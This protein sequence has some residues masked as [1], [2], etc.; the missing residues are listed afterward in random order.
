M[1]RT[2]HGFYRSKAVILRLCKKRAI[3]PFSWAVCVSS[4]RDVA[5]SKRSRWILWGVQPH[6]IMTA[7]PRQ[8]K[9]CA[10]SP[11][12]SLTLEAGGR[13]FP[14]PSKSVALRK[15]AAAPPSSSHRAI[16]AWWLDRLDDNVL[17]GSS[18]LYMGSMTAA[19]QQAHR[20]AR[21]EPECSRVSLH[22]S[23]LRNCSMKRRAIVS[24]WPG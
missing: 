16:A 18:F 4:G 13:S 15:V 10:S 22:R 20:A 17:F 3:C 14:D 19:Y 21:G 23:R 24:V 8:S 7:A 2:G 6:R 9:T 1:S 5:H 12:S 11:E